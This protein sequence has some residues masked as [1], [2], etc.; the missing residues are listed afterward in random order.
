MRARLLTSSTP[1]YEAQVV[2][3]GHLVLHHRRGV[4]QLGRVVLVVSG[5][6]RDQSPV[7]H[8]TKSHDLHAGESRRELWVTEPHAYAQTMRAKPHPDPL[9]S[10]QVVQFIRNVKKKAKNPTPHRH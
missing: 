10:K 8:V 9:I 3:A 1:A 6:H 4:P 5:H 2:K 7:G